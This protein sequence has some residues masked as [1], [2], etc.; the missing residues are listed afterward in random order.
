MISISID[1][2][3]QFIVRLNLAIFEKKLNIDRSQSCYQKYVLNRILSEKNLS[4]DTCTLK[5]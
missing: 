4:L 2:C 3:D 1:Y 5:G